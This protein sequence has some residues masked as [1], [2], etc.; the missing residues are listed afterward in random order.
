MH[1]SF[2]M[3]MESGETFDARI[4]PFRLAVPSVLI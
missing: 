2:Q 4:E 1:G 3:A